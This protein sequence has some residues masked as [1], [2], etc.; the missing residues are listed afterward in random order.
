MT[1]WAPSAVERPAG[2]SR[3]M[4][5]A[6]FRGIFPYMVSPVDEAG[7]VREAALRKL[8]D[9]LIASGV[10]GLSPLGSTGEFAYLTFEQRA[11][12]VRIVVDA[13]A[14]RVPVLPG[15]AAFAIDDAR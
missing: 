8:V 6:S 7:R 15:V 12:I 14:G 10:H 11:D 9:H 13:T 3:A 1:P 2:G 5:G 4:D